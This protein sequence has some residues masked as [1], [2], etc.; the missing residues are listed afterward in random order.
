M[1]RVLVL[2]LLLPCV[3]F[4]APGYLTDSSGI[5]VRSTF[6]DCWRTSDWTRMDAIPE[7]DPDLFKVYAVEAPK[8]MLAMPIPTSIPAFIADI[9]IEVGKELLKEGLTEG[10]KAAFG[11]M[12]V[13]AVVF[14]QN[15]LFVSHKLSAD[16]KKLLGYVLREIPKDKAITVKTQSSAETLAVMNYLLMN[17]FSSVK[18][19]TDP[20]FSGV[21]L[22]L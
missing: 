1:Q 11:A 5:P 21:E 14:K 3:A 7:C 4:A 17:G 20:K 12:R 16:G 6:G 19:L 9:L 2:L 8:P 13:K 18:V 10:V 22:E 15:D